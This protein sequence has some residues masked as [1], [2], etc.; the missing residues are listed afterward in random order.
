M[1]IS[2][3]CSSFLLAVYSDTSS[4][5]FDDKIAEFLHF[6]GIHTI[7]WV[8][9]RKKNGLC[10]STSEE[11]FVTLQEVRGHEA[12]SISYKERET[13]TGPAILIISIVAVLIVG[14]ALTIVYVNSQTNSIV[15]ANQQLVES[16]MALMEKNKR[17]EATIGQQSEQ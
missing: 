9:E 4:S 11:D 3:L 14:F 6:A 17:Q 13:M 10:G 1:L 15:K 2:T 5:S 7:N 12:R 8:Y 16:Q